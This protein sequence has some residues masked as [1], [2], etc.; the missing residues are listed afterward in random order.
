MK[1]RNDRKGFSMSGKM[2][3][4]LVLCLL[5]LVAIFLFSSQ[6]AETSHQISDWFLQSV[7][8]IST[9]NYE[10]ASLTPL[11]FGLSIRKYAHI[12]LY[13]LL[14]ICIF[15]V[16]SDYV[17]LHTEHF[18]RVD[19]RRILWSK[20]GIAFGICMIFAILDEIHQIFSVGRGVSAW[21]VLIDAIGF[22]LA[23]CLITFFCQSRKLFMGVLCLLIL[24]VLGGCVWRGARQDYLEKNRKDTQIKQV[25]DENIYT[26]GAPTSKKVEY[27]SEHTKNADKSIKLSTNSKR[28]ASVTLINLDIDVS[29]DDILGFWF[30]T[31]RDTIRQ[32]S[33]D[34]KAK[35]MVSIN[36]SVEICIADCYKS[37]GGLNIAKLKK[38]AFV[39][40]IH[41]LKFSLVPNTRDDKEFYIDSIQLNYKEPTYVIF[42]FD[43]T[44][45]EFYETG[46]PLFQKYGIK[47]TFSFDMSERFSEKEAALY[48]EMLSEGFDYGVFSSTDSLPFGERPAG[49]Y[50][51]YSR[52]SD[53][54]ANMMQVGQL[55]GIRAPSVCM[56]SQNKVGEIY[57]RAMTDAGFMINRYS[58]SNNFLDYFD[59]EYREFP[60]YGWEGARYASDSQVD[61]FEKRLDEAL[62]YGYSLA[63]DGG[64]LI[65]SGEEVPSW[66][67]GEEALEEAIQYAVDMQNAG[68]CKIVTFAEYMKL[69]HPEIYREWSEK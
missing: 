41:K 61:M 36:D 44:G 54:A 9:L 38:G 35:L 43:S 64:K 40:T 17:E 5:L 4:H 22:V 49:F 7:L 42:N 20:A 27:S 28:K 52:W 14:G 57:D 58:T 8:H 46:Y 6:S 3:F 47:A 13:F 56:S 45:E 16:V 65:P 59:E 25:S 32:H 62:E 1:K 18:W 29:K 11:L 39:G 15:F 50:T 12:F 69:E 19:E 34:S 2:I 67:V 48:R 55:W 66:C 37:H 30:W 24:G 68:K 60:T 31:T 53:F 63:Y 51:D 33:D 10:G 23:I 26:L 21:D